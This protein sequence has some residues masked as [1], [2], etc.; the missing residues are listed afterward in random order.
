MSEV[1]GELR[2]KIKEINVAVINAHDLVNGAK[3]SVYEN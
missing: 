1:Y 3:I 2:A